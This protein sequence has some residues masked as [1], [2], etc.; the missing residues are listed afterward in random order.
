MTKVSVP[1]TFST[2]YPE[3]SKDKCFMKS[4]KI[5]GVP[6]K[7]ISIDALTLSMFTMASTVKGI[8]WVTAKV[9]NK[10]TEITRWTTNSTTAVPMSAT[11]AFIGGEGES[12]TIEW[13]LLTSV[14]SVRVKI[15]KLTY[16]YSVVDGDTVDTPECL[17]VVECKT[18]AEAT[19][20]AATLADQGANVYT[21]KA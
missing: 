7:K 14:A 12:I 6:G 5:P 2:I 18:Q 17:V 21:R 19:A 9:E 15:N 10:S 20:L 3:C 8:C 11:P 16:T 13:R 4:I 1:N